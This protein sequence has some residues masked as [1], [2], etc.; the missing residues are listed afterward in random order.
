MKGVLEPTDYRESST[1][2]PFEIHKSRAG[3]GSEPERLKWL[4]SRG[5]SGRLRPALQ[6]RRAQLA[7]KGCPGQTPGPGSA[8]FFGF[9][10]PQTLG[11]SLVPCF[12]GWGGVRVGGGEGW[13]VSFCF[14]PRVELQRVSTPK[15]QCC[16]VDSGLAPS[17]AMVADSQTVKKKIIP[18]AETRELPDRSPLREPGQHE[19][20][21]QPPFSS[22]LGLR[23]IHTERP[24]R[25]G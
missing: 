8:F 5:T 15:N 20:G 10:S 25:A 22:S 21:R 16:L 18:A 9:D 13:G 7:L 23:Q 4:S 1:G 19:G 2:F 17:S 11:G 12:G 24:L 3:N 14:S 6:T